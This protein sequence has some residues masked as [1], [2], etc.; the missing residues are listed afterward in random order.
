MWQNDLVLTGIYCS[1]QNLPIC[2]NKGDLTRKETNAQ[3]A[4][5]GNMKPKFEKPST[6]L[7]AHWRSLGAQQGLYLLQL[8]VTKRKSD[9]SRHSKW[10]WL[11]RAQQFWWEQVKNGANQTDG[12]KVLV[13]QSL[14]VSATKKSVGVY[15]CLCCFISEQWYQT[16]GYR[17]IYGLKVSRKRNNFA[18]GTNSKGPTDQTIWWF[19]GSKFKL[20]WLSLLIC[21]YNFGELWNSN[22]ITKR[23]QSWY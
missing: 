17:T 18:I 11:A 8:F 15:Y 19:K 14:V 20:R 1:K 13:Y 2:S 12:S 16:I 10:V 21:C 5:A 4:I 3:A 7:L 22:R 9:R 6:I 23:Y